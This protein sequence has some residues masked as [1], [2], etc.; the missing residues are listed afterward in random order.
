[1]SISSRFAVGIHIL[2]LLEIN[3]NGVNSSEFIAGSVN[4]NPVVI[5]KIMGMLKNAGLVKVRPGIAGAELAKELSDITLLDVY[6]AVNVVQEKELFSVHESPN[7]TCPVGRNIQDAIVPLL[8]VA[9]LA[10]EKALGNVT[11]EDVV[12]D[13]LEKEKMSNH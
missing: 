3:N 8:S 4:T 7:P 2:S 12:K 1:M 6:K 5:R 9:E 13:I 10:L 11:I